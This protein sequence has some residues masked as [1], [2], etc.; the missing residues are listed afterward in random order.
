MFD[1]AFFEQHFHDQMRMFAREHKLTNPV[2]EFVL[3]DGSELF[4]RGVLQTRESWLCLVAYDAETTRQIYCPYY[5]IK[6]ITLYAQSPPAAK[7]RDVAFQL[8]PGGR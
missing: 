8:Q 3:D 5:S 4:V 6:R 1:R 2:V 7:G